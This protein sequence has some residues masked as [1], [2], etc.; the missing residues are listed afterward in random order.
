M[1]AGL[2]RR[3]A[4]VCLREIPCRFI[5][6]GRAF[7]RE[8]WTTSHQTGRNST[9]T[10]RYAS[11]CLAAG[12]RAGR[13][14]R[15]GPLKIPTETGGITLRLAPGMCA[16][17]SVGYDQQCYPGGDPLL[18]REHKAKTTEVKWYRVSHD[19]P[20]IFPPSDYVH[21]PPSDPDENWMSPPPGSVSSASSFHSTQNWDSPETE[22]AIVGNDS[23]VF[24]KGEI[25]AIFGGTGPEAGEEPLNWKLAP[26]PTPG[27]APWGELPALF[28]GDL[29]PQDLLDYGSDMF[30][31]EGQL[32]DGDPLHLL[33][34]PTSGVQSDTIDP[35]DLFSM[36][37]IA[38]ERSPSLY[39]SDEGSPAAEGYT[40]TPL[41]AEPEEFTLPSLLGSPASTTPSRNSSS[42]SK[43]SPPHTP[44]TP[45]PD[46][47][48]AHPSF[49]PVDWEAELAPID[50]DSDFGSGSEFEI[51]D[52]D[53]DDE[54]D[55]RGPPAKKARMN[56]AEASS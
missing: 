6:L 36:P 28:G 3:L 47:N 8:R 15:D 2:G 22:E 23:G 11:I 45:C 44:D 55:P 48:P 33:D 1:N 42:S 25:D 38:A 20:P 51:E 46:P 21:P 31:A 14:K 39:D 52:D 10:A 34:D 13:R 56:L 16:A 37:L 54:Y 17:Q 12:A 9:S 43:I 50:V 26:V 53:D 29:G 41:P 30:W 19:P 49:C 32:L 18:A 27:L 7:A 24:L 4:L 5:L 35:R 40:P